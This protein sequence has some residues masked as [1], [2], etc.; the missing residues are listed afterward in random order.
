[1]VA[2]FSVFI[3]RKQSPA[4]REVI[5]QRLEQDYLIF[6]PLIKVSIP[7]IGF[8]FGAGDQANSISKP[9][10]CKSSINQNQLTLLSI[11]ILR[12]AW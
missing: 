10:A 2:S 5:I 1:M 3:M 12:L 8:H 7:A 11:T 9:A 6:G 4:V